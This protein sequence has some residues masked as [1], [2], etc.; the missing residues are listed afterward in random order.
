M[1]LRRSAL[2]NLCSA[3]MRTSDSNHLFFRAAMGG[4]RFAELAK[5][6]R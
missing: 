1:P 4:I 5:I 3:V 2:L 6:R